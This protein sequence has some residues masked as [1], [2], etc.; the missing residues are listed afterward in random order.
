[1]DHTT[2]N[3]FAQLK[4]HQ[5]VFTEEQIVNSRTQNSRTQNNR[6]KNPKDDDLF[7]KHVYRDKGVSYPCRA[8]GILPFAYIDN[9]PYICFQLDHRQFLT[10]F[11]GK[12]E[13]KDIDIIATAA[14]EAAEESNGLFLTN[15]SHSALPIEEKILQSGQEIR[16]E[17]KKILSNSNN[18]LPHQSGK[19]VTFIINIDY[20]PI[21]KLGC[22]EITEN[23]PRE[24]TWIPL[25]FIL[26]SKFNVK[27]L[28]PR[29]RP[30]IP[31]LRQLFPGCKAK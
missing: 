15:D 14:R 24:I 1:M 11:G 29:I 22:H 10:D 30:I 13:F 16:K 20:I 8:S 25:L 7:P 28:H 2:N 17:I 21:E 12:R 5:K 4:F 3:R 27:S 9:V 23:I 26:N 6:N 31:K 19:Y 18:I